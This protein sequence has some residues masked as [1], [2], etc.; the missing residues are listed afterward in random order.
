MEQEISRQI[1]YM[2]YSRTRNT[3]PIVQ[4]DSY[5]KATAEAARLASKHPGDE[6]VILKSVAT[7]AAFIPAPT[8]YIHVGGKGTYHV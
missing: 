3:Y 4:H 1:F 8:C 6:F 2:I 5:D 7:M